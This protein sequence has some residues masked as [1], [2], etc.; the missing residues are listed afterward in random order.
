MSEIHQWLKIRWDS[1]WGGDGKKVNGEPMTL[2]KFL[3]GLESQGWEI[4]ACAKVSRSLDW[5]IICR[6]KM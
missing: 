1:G 4:F 3:E 6:R 2:V 5:D